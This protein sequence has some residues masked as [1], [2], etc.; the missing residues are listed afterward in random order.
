[1]AAFWML[2]VADAQDGECTT[3]VEAVADGWWY[4]T[5]VPGHRRVVAFLTDYDLLPPR[6]A[7]NGK[8]WHARIARAPHISDQLAS[9]GCRLRSSPP[10]VD[11]SVALLDHPAGCGWVAAGDAA[12]SFDPLSSQGILTALVMGQ[13]AGQAVAAML[14]RRD[15]NPLIRWGA[16]YARLL[17][18]HLRLQAAYYAVERRWPSAPFWARR[19]RGYS[20]ALN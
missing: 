15:Q 3:L 13:G 7:R 10:I 19:Q 4:T 16:E 14:T 1:V 20:D 6:A 8:D 17:E 11:A 18:A 5:P 12:V 9:S 2:P